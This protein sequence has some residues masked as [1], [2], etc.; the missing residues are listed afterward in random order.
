MRIL[1]GFKTTFTQCA[2]VYPFLFLCYLFLF[3]WHESV[4]DFIVDRN[5]SS[6]ACVRASSCILLCN[7]LYSLN[8][9]WYINRQKI[10]NKCEQMFAWHAGLWHTLSLSFSLT[11]R[12]QVHQKEKDISG[13]LIA[14]QRR[15]CV[16]VCLRMTHR[17]QLLASLAR[18]YTIHTND[19]IESC[20]FF[21]ISIILLLQNA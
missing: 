1:K 5:A 16:Y 4:D 21:S 9:K 20:D 11:R 14:N 8:N 19:S 10:Y 18:C 3:F 15:V 17:T 13:N 12:R 7:I 6:N 2:W